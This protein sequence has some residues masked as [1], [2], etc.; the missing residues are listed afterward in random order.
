MEDSTVETKSKSNGSVLCFRKYHS[1]E[2]PSCKI[3]FYNNIVSPN[4][5]VFIPGRDDLSS[6]TRAQLK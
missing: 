5:A 4:P 3:Q 6:L 2:I 1:C